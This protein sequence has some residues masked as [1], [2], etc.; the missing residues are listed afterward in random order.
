MA[1]KGPLS[2]VR[3]PIASSAEVRPSVAAGI[4]FA[5]PIEADAFARRVERG[6]TLD[7]AGLA[8]HEGRIDGRPIAWC[9][10]GAGP[11]AAAKAARLL[12]AGHRPKLLIAAGFAGGLDLT[13]PRGTVVLPSRALCQAGGPPLALA[14]HPQS[15]LPSGAPPAADGT[16]ASIVSVGDV[17][18]SPAAKQALAAATGAILVDMETYAVAQ[19]A[20][21]AGLPCACVRVVSDT[22]GQ[23]LPREVSALARPQSGMRRLGAALGAIGRRP[24]AALD[25]WQLWENAVVDGRTLG[26]EL[27]DVCR[28]LPE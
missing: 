5:L 4:V 19:V 2:T 16:G 6:V 23:E 15:A 21:D 26:R 3:M 24:R 25:L 7:A 10:A 14:V 9:V 20:R 22:A 27:E 18:T 28:R 11:T 17:V 1:A 8:F 12:I 13:L